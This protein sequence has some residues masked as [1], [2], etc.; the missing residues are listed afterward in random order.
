MRFTE[1]FMPATEPK[2]DVIILTPEMLLTEKIPLL[3]DPHREM[4]YRETPMKGITSQEELVKELSRQLKNQQ[5]LAA[6]PNTPEN[7]KA[8]HQKNIAKL[9]QA[10]REAAPEKQSET[11]GST[12]VP[13]IFH[14]FSFF[15]SQKTEQNQP[16]TTETHTEKNASK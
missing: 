13:S 2:P 12:G 7:C 3:E 14:A 10:L 15:Y 9:T 1:P 8:M 11:T 16:S 4:L 5:E 6:K